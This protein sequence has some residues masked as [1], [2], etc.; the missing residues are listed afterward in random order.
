M[1]DLPSLFANQAYPSQGPF[2]APVREI[3]EMR[4]A[5]LNV[6]FVR[7]SYGTIVSGTPANP[8]G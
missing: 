6:D 3:Y 5:V 4:K 7:L 2:P 1:D 8:S